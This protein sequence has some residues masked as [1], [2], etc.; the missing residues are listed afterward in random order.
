MRISECIIHLAQPVLGK[1]RLSGAVTVGTT[2][3][4]YTFPDDP[5][6]GALNAVPEHAAGR[7]VLIPITN[8]TSVVIDPG[9]DT[10]AH[11]P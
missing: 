2:W 7:R 6:D 1:I 9:A 3:L 11:L 4:D 8:V 5:G 10:G